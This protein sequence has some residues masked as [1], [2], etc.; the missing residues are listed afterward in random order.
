M[1]ARYPHRF[2]RVYCELRLTQGARGACLLSRI[3]DPHAHRANLQRIAVVHG[4]DMRTQTE[5]AWDAGTEA[6]HFTQHVVLSC[7]EVDVPSAIDPSGQIQ[8][9][10]VAKTDD[11]ADADVQNTHQ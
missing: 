11:F 3:G 7:Y 5:P 10:L 8:A 6:V 1:G 9:D 4:E 2:G